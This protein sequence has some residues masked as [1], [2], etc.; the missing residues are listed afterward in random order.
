MKQND[1]S[2]PTPRPMMEND[3][4]ILDAIEMGEDKASVDAPY[5][6]DTGH[7]NAAFT[8]DARCSGEQKVDNSHGPKIVRYGNDRPSVDDVIKPE[9]QRMRLWIS[10]TVCLP[11]YYQQF[12]QNG[13][14]TLDI[15]KEIQHREEL[16]DIGIYRTEHQYQI[17][18]EISKLKEISNHNDDG[19][20][21]IMQTSV[22]DPDSVVV[23]D[24]AE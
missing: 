2:Y 4:E 9:I 21:N 7:G 15:I 17:L 20:N 18:A 13:Y 6:W 1:K 12:L 5:G 10:D 16:M 23:E 24:C 3:G 19:K 11:Q 14:E 22:S 8:E